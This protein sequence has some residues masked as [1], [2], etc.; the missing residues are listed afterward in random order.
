MKLNTKQNNN[1]NQSLVLPSKVI[2][3]KP[4][5]LRFTLTTLGKKIRIKL[6]HCHLNIQ[7]RRATNNGAISV[8]SVV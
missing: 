5:H 8:V 7:S 6:K 2:L 1:K 3:T 4:P